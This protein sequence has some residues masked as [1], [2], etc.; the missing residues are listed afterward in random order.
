MPRWGRVIRLVGVVAVLAAHARGAP[1][2]HR[3]AEGQT[4]GAIARRYG[5][6]TEE[7]AAANEMSESDVLAIGRRLVIPDPAPRT[8]PNAPPSE[9]AE[10]V[11]VAGD[12]LGSIALHH[13]VSLT[14]LARA[15]GVREA[16]LLRVGQRLRIPPE[17]PRSEDASAPPASG[18]APARAGPQRLDLPGAAPAYFYEPEGSGRSGLRPVIFYLHGRGAEP[19]HDCQRWAPI[20][21][22]HGWLVCPSGAGYHGGGRTWNNDWSAGQAAVNASLAALRARFGRRVQ[23]YGNTLIGFSEGAFVAMNVG[24]RAPRTFN[25]WLILGASDGYLGADGAGLVARSRASLRRVVLLTG[26]HD[27]VVHETRRAGV[28]FEGSGVP[29]RLL[30]PT[31]LGHELALEREPALYRDALA[32]LAAG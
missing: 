8:R 25:R 9:A 15:N 28:W 32:W 13:R 5:V 24:V 16:D 4:L 27:A 30:T 10:H 22:R 11:V 18:P 2:E 26:E 6:T 14:G 29:L 20:V 23:L 1:R 21:R 17:Q 7:L 31:S 12:T 3:V 19:A